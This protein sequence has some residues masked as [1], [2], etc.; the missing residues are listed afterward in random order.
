MTS[1]SDQ[2]RKIDAFQRDWEH[3]QHQADIGVR[4]FGPDP[5]AA[6]AG[7]ALAMTAVMVDPRTVR[8]VNRVS[9]NCR[10]SG[11]ELLLYDWLNALIYEMS[12][13]KMLFSSFEVNIF[14]HYQ[15]QAEARGE[16]LRLSRHYPAVEIKGATFTELVVREVDAGRWLVQC[17]VDV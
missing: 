7:A 14:D 3:F 16:N 5:A 15:L 6:F 8:P 2:P 4:G 13:R 1:I 11:L 9:I 17:V 10:A 12:T